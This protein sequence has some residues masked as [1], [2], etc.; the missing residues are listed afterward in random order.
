MLRKIL[1]VA[2]VAVMIFS[3]GCKKTSTE[4][5]TK[6]TVQIKQAEKDGQA[7]T[8]TIKKE[9]IKETETTPIAE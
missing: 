6:N 9:T 8:E 1:T 5:E 7:V 4:T 2:F 3:F